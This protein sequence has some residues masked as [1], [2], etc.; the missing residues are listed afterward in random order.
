MSQSKERLLKASQ[1]RIT[2]LD[3]RELQYHRPMATVEPLHLSDALPPEWKEKIL[4]APRVRHKLEVEIGPGK[5]EFLARRAAEHPDRFFLGIDRRLDRFRLTQKKLERAAA[6]KNW[7][8]LREDARAFLETELPP[9]QILHIYHPDPWPKTR[10]HKHRFF[11]SPDARRWAEAVVPGGELRLSTDH[12][13]YFIE[14][15]DIVQSWKRFELGLVFEKRAHMGA[16][17]S[18]FE[19]IFFRKNEPV[20]KAV[21]VRPPSK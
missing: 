2:L 15:I 8:V 17:Q 7:C 1:H 5:G 3:G 12:R 13:E 18:H 19:N 11:R 4:G 14:I 20:F 21:F 6:G 9:I 16:A 10:H